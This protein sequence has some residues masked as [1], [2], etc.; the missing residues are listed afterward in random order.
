MRKMLYIVIALV[1]LFALSGCQEEGIPAY[2]TKIIGAFSDS[3]GI[4]LDEWRS[5]TFQDE[6][7]PQTLTVCSLL[8]G[9]ELVGTYR[10]SCYD[11]KLSF[12]ADVYYTGDGTRFEV[13]SGTTEVVQTSAVGGDYFDVQPGMTTE[14]GS[15]EEAVQ[16][17]YGLLAELVEDPENYE[18]MEARENNDLFTD[19][20]VTMAKK[21]N[22]LWSADSVSINITHAG[23]VSVIRLGDVGAFSGRRFQNQTAR[24]MNIDT[25]SSSILEKTKAAYQGSGQI[26]SCAPENL[27]VVRYQDG[28]YYI[29]ADVEVCFDDGSGTRIQTLTSLPQ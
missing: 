7:A 15:A 3:G 23:T 26:T 12:I 20:T 1:F 27:T 25:V 28:N 2:E 10:W 9:S 16:R 17:A 11:P 8:D 21:I 24:Q 22:G 13:K 4:T 29:L 18:L 19:Y 6:E 5:S 14:V